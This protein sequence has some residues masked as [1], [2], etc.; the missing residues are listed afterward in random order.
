MTD[1]PFLLEFC[2]SQIEKFINGIVVRERTFLRYLAKAGIDGFDCVGRIHDLTNG[3]A[4]VKQLLDVLEI[5]CPDVD[6]TR[7]GF[8]GCLE[9]FKSGLRCLKAGSAIHFPEITSEFFKSFAGTYAADPNCADFSPLASAYKNI[10]LNR[11]EHTAT[12]EI[13]E[14]GVTGAAYTADAVCGAIPPEEEFDFVL[15]RPFCF[16]IVSS[17]RSILFSGVVQTID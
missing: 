6:C 11:A 3:I 14:E 16:A 15:D 8:P 1:V 2:D 4:I 12:V 13:N 5:A 9:S 7:I 10:W 17:D